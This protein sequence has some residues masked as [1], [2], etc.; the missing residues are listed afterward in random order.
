MPS[1]LSY[2]QANAYDNADIV[3]LY[4]TRTL[5]GVQSLK[6]SWGAEAEYY[7][8]QGTRAPAGV[9]K[10]IIKPE[11]ELILLINDALALDAYRQ[12]NMGGA[13]LNSFMD[14]SAL[15]Q[16][17]ISA[18]SASTHIITLTQCQLVG[19]AFVDTQSPDTRKKLEVSYK[20]MFTGGTIDGIP[21]L[22]NSTNTLPAI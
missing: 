11:G 20:L 8:V 17:R 14:V 15:L 7:W 5:S 2:Y 18:S 16:I 13:A 3:F 19:A 10:T 21:L 6:H 9:T 1:T 4:G 22:N 12:N